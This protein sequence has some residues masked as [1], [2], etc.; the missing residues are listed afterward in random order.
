[1]PNILIV[2]DSPID[3]QL[4]E[5]I[6]TKQVGITIF[7]AENGFDALDKIADWEIDLVITDLQMPKMDGLELVKS[8]RDDHP[9]VPT[10]LATGV[11]SEE[12]ASQALVAGATGYVPK[13][14]ASEMLWPTVKSVFDVL[15]TEHSFDRLLGTATETRFEFNLDNDESYFPAI[16]ELCDRMLESLSPLDRIERLRCCVAIEHALNNALF[17]GNLE[18]DQRTEREVKQG[19]PDSFSRFVSARKNEF[20]NRTIQVSID[21]KTFGFVCR[22]RDQGTG[23][24]PKPAGEFNGKSGRG[25]IIMRMF[26]DNVE[27]NRAGNEVTLH[28]NWR[29]NPS[30]D[31]VD[32]ELLLDIP[33][34][35]EA[36]NL[37]V[38]RCLDSDFSLELSQP[39]QLVGR[40]TTCHIVLDDN[41]VS[42]HHCELVFRKGV[43]SIQSLAHHE[44]WVNGKLTA[45]AELSALDR[46]KIGSREYQVQYQ[47]DK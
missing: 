22:I 12:V 24:T 26:M 1:M 5:G 7:Q 33:R 31:T 32:S 39:M 28:R 15:N 41:E 25:L 36:F 21:I 44:I 46:I 3:R 2:D 13:E 42:P 29:S 37:G 6:L 23:F 17:R 30:V 45:F 14:K 43:W 10:I 40:G 34:Q 8:I 38:F 9:T 19:G 16:N 47:A 4:F 27:F 20:S 11:G 18:I 35:R